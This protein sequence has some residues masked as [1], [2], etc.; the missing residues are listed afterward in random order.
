MILI[1]PKEKKKN[2]DSNKKKSLKPAA[3]EVQKTYLYAVNHFDDIAKLISKSHKRKFFYPL[4]IAPKEYSGEYSPRWSEQEAIESIVKQID[5]YGKKRAD[6]KHNSKT[7]NY[8]N[9]DLE[10]GEIAQIAKFGECIQFLKNQPKQIN[11]YVGNVTLPRLTTMPVDPH[12][13][14]DIYKYGVG[15]I[16]ISILCFKRDEASDLNFN[17]MNYFHKEKLNFLLK[18][19]QMDKYEGDPDYF[20]NQ[21]SD[22]QAFEDE[23]KYFQGIDASK[24]TFDHYV[25]YTAD[26]IPGDFE[27]ADDDYPGPDPEPPWK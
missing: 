4:T 12:P 1:L 25:P 27:Y 6:I 24:V 13:F 22:I 17:Y 20:E 10:V 15:E 3:F 19:K 26:E 9:S 8:G 21:H 11:L 5:D 23:I 14:N 2:Y 16:T 18:E 7:E